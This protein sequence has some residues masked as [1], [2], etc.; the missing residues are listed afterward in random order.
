M[1]TC[2]LLF[3]AAFFLNCPAF[4]LQANP[5]TPTAYQQLCALNKYWKQHPVFTK[6]LNEPR[7]FANHEA[8]IACHLQWVVY[9]LHQNPP[10]HLTAA[11]Q[12]N[13]LHCL[14]ILDNYRKAAVFPKN[15]HHTFTI[16]YFIDDYNTA[17]AVGHLIRETGYEDLAC[18]IAAEM[19]YAFLED[20]PYAEIGQWANTMGFDVAELKW[21]Q[22]AYAPPVR[23]EHTQTPATCGQQN[24]SIDMAVV[25]YLTSV[26]VTGYTQKWYSLRGNTLG[27]V[28]EAEDITNMPAGLYKPMV[29]TNQ[30]MFAFVYDLIGLNDDSG[31]DITASVV[32]ETCTNSKDGSITLNISGG[33]PPY[34]VIWYNQTGAVAGNGLSLQNLSG[35]GY[36]IMYPILVAPYTAEVTDA[37]GCKTFATFN[38][39]TLYET[40][41]AYPNITAPGCQQSN[42]A[43]EL[44]YLPEGAQIQWSHNAALTSNI[45]QN[46]AA[47]LYT[48]TITTTQG[49]QTTQSFA[50][51]DAEA[52]NI[53]SVTVTPDDCQQ[54]NGSVTLPDVPGNAYG[55]SHNAGWHLHYANNLQ[56]GFYTVTVTNAAGCQKVVQYYVQN[57]NF[58][59]SYAYTNTEWILVNANSNAGTTGS[60][61]LPEYGMAPL[62]Y[63]WSHN[64]GLNSRIA[65]NLQP[66][67]YTV[68]VTNTQ[69]GC[70]AEL[71]FEI[72]DAA[73][74]G[75]SAGHTLPQYFGAQ[76]IAVGQ[77]LTLSYQ[78]NG[79]DNLHLQIV[80]LQGKTLLYNN[81]GAGNGLHSLALPLQNA[82]AGLYVLRLYHNTG[83]QTVKFVK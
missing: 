70:P 48:V 40:P 34:S 35:T 53:V 36:D 5:A 27:L 49:C 56:S 1:K 45:A 20:M 51:S 50:V 41:W 52:D 82:P 8:L 12:H 62:A 54:H 19:N 30:G 11:Q 32:P 76:V 65:D 37:G 3:A 77:N 47:G 75:T 23:I 31:P 80:D 67:T 2:I 25:D 74:L 57:A 22:P 72:Y 59:D 28:T 17:C 66:G 79:S 68:T 33:T 81:L 73:F 4:L 55:W 29:Q 39:E 42:G 18:R 21:I 16:P 71:S 6:E 69:T 14:Q 64:P 26:P 78:Y 10:A 83:S 44:L 63:S 13:R 38:L 43:I 61:E 24:G 46:L 15:T 60:I 7:F 58:A 9:Y